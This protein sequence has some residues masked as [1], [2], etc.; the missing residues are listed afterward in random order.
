MN[1][2]PIF[3]HSSTRTRGT[4][5]AHAFESVQNAMVFF[6]PLSPYL[7]GYESAR[8]VN[9]SN[10]HSN[11][12]EDYEY[13]KSYFT[14]DKDKWHPYIPNPTNFVFRNSSNDYKQELFIYLDSLIRAAFEK[15]RIPVFKFETLEGHAS[16]LSEKFPNS[17]NI[18]TIRDPEEHYL[19]WQEQLALGLGGN[20]GVARKLIEGDPDFFSVGRTN[21]EKT[22][23]WIFETYYNGLLTLR[24]E[25]DFCIDLTLDSKQQILD[26]LE[27]CNKSTPKHLEA[28]K[29]AL[30]HVSSGVELKTK[31]RRM[32]NHQITTSQQR[33]EL[34]QQRD[35]LTQQISAVNNSWSWRLTKPLRILGDVFKN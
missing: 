2:A 24:P 1:T 10:W 19:S 30:V 32:I 11:H 28:F 29:Q 9:S 22:N 20:F 31:L 7:N 33:D 15:G 3:I 35:E 18:G 14:I 5:L 8:H 23:E 25:L 12:P 27:Q 16:F 4:L 26:K 34:T 21:S 17:I 13:F 6:D